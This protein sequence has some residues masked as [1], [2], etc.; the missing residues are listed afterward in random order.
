MVSGLVPAQ[1]CALIMVLVSG[2]REHLYA[3]SGR[4]LWLNPCERKLS[5][6]ALI[7]INLL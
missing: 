6:L 7:L 3:T 5:P 2:E 4:S 1:L